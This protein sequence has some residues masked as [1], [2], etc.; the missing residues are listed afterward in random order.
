MEFPRRTFLKLGGAAAAVGALEGGATVRDGVLDALKGGV[1]L[2]EPSRSAEAKIRDFESPFRGDEAFK[3]RAQAT[4]EGT[5]AS[6]HGY[7]HAHYEQSTARKMPSRVQTILANLVPGLAGQESKFDITAVNPRT[8]ASG[9]MQVLPHTHANKH[10]RKALT[11]AEEAAFIKFAADYKAQVEFSFDYFDLIYQ[12]YT[13]EK[14]IDFNRLGRQF[15]L[16]SLQ[17]DIFTTFCLMNG[18]NVGMGWFGT[19]LVYFAENFDEDNLPDSCDGTALSLFNVFAEFFYHRNGP[20]SQHYAEESSEYVFRS[21]AGNEVLNDMF[22]TDYGLKEVGSFEDYLPKTHQAVAAVT[23]WMVA[24]S[25]Q[26]PYFKKR[27]LG[28]PVINVAASTMRTVAHT[29]KGVFDIVTGAGSAAPSK[30]KGKKKT[31]KKAPVAKKTARG[32]GEKTSNKGG[33]NKGR[34]KPKPSPGPTRRQ[35]IGGTAAGILGIGAGTYASLD[36]SDNGKIDGSI[37]WGEDDDEAEANLSNSAEFS[38]K[39]VPKE[40]IRLAARGIR[41]SSSGKAEN[42][43]GLVDAGG[44]TTLVGMRKDV[45]QAMETMLSDLGLL[46]SEANME[47][48]YKDFEDSDKDHIT[49]INETFGFNRTSQFIITGLAESGQRTRNST[50]SQSGHAN[51]YA[52]D[53]ATLTGQRFGS[54]LF[55]GV[56][57]ASKAAGAKYDKRF[58]FP[59][60]HPLMQSGM[61]VG[62]TLFRY[63]GHNKFYLFGLRQG[64]QVY[65]CWLNLE[66]NHRHMELIPWDNYHKEKEARGVG[67]SDKLKRVWQP[68]VRDYIQENL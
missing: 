28:R 33:S 48:L 24:D 68:E 43:D 67:F 31:A 64:D 14:N 19:L 46:R 17:R 34:R 5:E 16:D 23:G 44:R 25:V 41:L 54:T 11:E 61:I 39:E 36:W 42:E 22:G 45:W 63:Q 51:G 62:N 30:P 12:H 8:N 66:G 10:P 37:L 1:D 32:E 57:E 38:A 35:M 26:D 40:M 15:G 27:W 49:Y 59:D 52:M 53:M 60:E 13:E 21:L 2:P 3:R 7:L 56:A 20:T 9:I 58:V 4:V 55:R 47:T 6:H 50:N 65:V 29:T 18:Y